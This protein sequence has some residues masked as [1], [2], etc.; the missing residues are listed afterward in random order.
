MGITLCAA[1]VEVEGEVEVEGWVVYLPGRARR[2]AARGIRTDRAEAVSLPHPACA[3]G[4]DAPLRGRGALRRAPGP[5]GRRG[6][7]GCL[8]LVRAAARAS[9]AGLGGR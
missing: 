2:E 8:D 6:G 3:C 1:W 7:A 4:E 9:R 5:A